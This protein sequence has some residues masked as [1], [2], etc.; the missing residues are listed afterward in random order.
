M[1]GQLTLGRCDHDGDSDDNQDN[2]KW[3]YLIA[4]NCFDLKIVKVWQSK[5]ESGQN[6]KCWAEK[7]LNINSEPCSVNMMLSKVTLLVLVRSAMLTRR[8]GRMFRMV[9]MIG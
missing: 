2:I 5:G 3:Q 8:R 7:A 1:V 4:V 6:T 9:K